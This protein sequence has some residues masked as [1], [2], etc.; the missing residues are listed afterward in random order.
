ML[1][2]L[3]NMDKGDPTAITTIINNTKLIKIKLTT[4]AQ[5][6]TSLVVVIIILLIEKLKITKTKIADISDSGKIS[7]MKIRFC[8]L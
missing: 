1:F 4:P 8:P 5:N 3:R 6:A 2:S 7:S